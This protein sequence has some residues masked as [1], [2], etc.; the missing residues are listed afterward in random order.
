MFDLGC[1]TH[2]SRGGGGAKLM[3]DRWGDKFMF[4]MGGRGGAKLMF[5][6]EGGAEFM[7]HQGRHIDLK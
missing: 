1:K 7:F 4:N 5:P 6:M 3:F 2:V